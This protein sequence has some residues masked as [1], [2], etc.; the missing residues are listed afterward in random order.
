M[1][2]KIDSPLDQIPAVNSVKI[3]SCTKSPALSAQ[4]RTLCS[5][6]KRASGTI[7]PRNLRER[8]TEPRGVRQ[9]AAIA[10]HPSVRSAIKCTLLASWT[11]TICEVIH[12]QSPKTF[13]K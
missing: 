3:S 6:N 13:R 5:R 4:D 8:E 12:P 11:V 2:H 10:E 7:P 1:Q 9:H